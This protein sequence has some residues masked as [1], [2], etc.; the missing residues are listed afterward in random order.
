MSSP[1]CRFSSSGP[2]RTFATN[3]PSVT[4]DGMSWRDFIERQNPDLFEHYDRDALDTSLPP[5]S[6]P[7]SQPVD[8]S[9]Q[10]STRADSQSQSL[11]TTTK[12]DLAQALDLLEHLMHPESTKRILPSKALYHPFLAESGRP[13]DDFHPHPFGQ[14]VCEKYHTIDEEG[15]PAIIDLDKNG[16][17]FQRKVEH[18]EAIA[19]GKEPCPFHRGALWGL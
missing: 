18:G 10:P 6:Q 8:A 9:S 14:G 7:P 3:V 4:Q 11:P 15:D 1:Y 5:S 19:I 17:S 13:D 2:G 12:D 16:R